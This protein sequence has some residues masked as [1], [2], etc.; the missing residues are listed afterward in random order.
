MGEPQTGKRTFGLPKFISSILSDVENL[1]VKLPLE[2][3]RVE[4]TLIVN[5]P[6]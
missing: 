2:H 6:L 3:G 1:A 5:T 4:L